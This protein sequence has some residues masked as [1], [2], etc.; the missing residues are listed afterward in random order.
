MAPLPAIRLRFT[1]R[2][3]DQCAV[4]YAEPFETIQVRAIKPQK[5]YLC[6]FTCLQTRAIYLETAWAVDT[7]SFF[8]A[9]ARFTSRRRVP[10]ETI[11]DNG[12]DFVGAVNEL[13]ELVSH[14]DEDTTQGTHVRDPTDEQLQHSYNFSN[15]YNLQSVF[16]ELLYTALVLYAGGQ[17]VPSWKSP[18]QA[19]VVGL[20]NSLRS[21]PSRHMFVLV[22]ISR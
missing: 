6:L 10:K 14:L 9:V 12:K 22:A 8:N 20:S 4:D 19:S 11:S 13:L 21:Y 3:F 1:F 15:Y 17:P 7:D 18:M 16:F 2:P 5:R